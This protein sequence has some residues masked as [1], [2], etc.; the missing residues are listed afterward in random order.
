MTTFAL[1]LARAIEARANPSLVALAAEAGLSAQ[2]ISNL[3]RARNQPSIR[4]AAAL[5]DVLD[6]P[7]LLTVAERARR[8]PCRVCGQEYVTIHNSQTRRVYCGHR[9]QQVHWNRQAALGRQRKRRKV[10]KAASFR[11][12]AAQKAVA[13][14]CRS[15]QWDGVCRDDSC[16]LRP[17]SPLPFIALSSV[18]KREAA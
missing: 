11:L 15:C 6:W 5:A 9:C 13:A 17:V 10:E 1:E 12:Q 16:E 2:T 4:A 14:F 3:R 7:K 8:R 18:K